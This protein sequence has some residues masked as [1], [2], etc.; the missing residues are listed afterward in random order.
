MLCL[1]VSVGTLL[2]QSLWVPGEESEVMQAGRSP[3]EQGLNHV[4]KEEV[5]ISSLRQDQQGLVQSVEEQL[6]RI[7]Q[8]I[9]QLSLHH[10]QHHHAHH[11][12]ESSPGPQESCH[13]TFD[14]GYPTCSEKVEFLRMR[15]QMDPC[16]AFYG[17]DGTTC[18]ILAYLSQVEDFCPP[19]RPGR[20][21]SVL[22][23]Q[24]TKRPYTEKAEVR[25]TLSLLYEMVSS[26]RGPA[27]GFVRSRVEHMS[28][29]WIQAGLRMRQSSNHTSSPQMKVLLYPG[30]LAGSAGQQFGSMVEKGGPLGEL[31]QWAD[32]SACL[33]I[34]G[35]NLTLSTSQDHLHSLIGAAPGRGSCPIQRPLPF[36]LIYTDYHGLAHLQ[37]AMGLAFQHY[38]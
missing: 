13:M 19:P 32:L 16:Y 11:E 30:I 29:E 35:H 28:Q 7:S 21:H 33:T 9:D 36:D 37:G 27:L 25:T 34:L 12:E 31:V 38:Q 24:Q 14:P 23:W 17:V 5:E 6:K 15:W 20:K 1:C 4:L 26:S 22:P 2:L 10:H 8:K 3:D 18:S